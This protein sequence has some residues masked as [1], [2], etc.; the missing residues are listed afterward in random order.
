MNRRRDLAVLAAR[1][2]LPTPLRGTSG[3]QR[4]NAILELT[5]PK[6]FVQELATQELYLLMHDIG[7]TDAYVLIEHA[8]ESQLEELIALDVW[9]RDDVQLERWL[10]W[11]DL[12]NACSHDVALRYIK[13]TDA[14]LLQLLLSGDIRVHG[15]DLDIDTVPDHLQLISS[16]DAMFK[17]TVPR[18]HPLE[19]RLP[20]L[21]KLLWAQS[22][23][24]MRTI[25]TATQF[26]LRAQLQESLYRF[27]NG[28]LE[29]MGLCSTEHAAEIYELVNPKSLRNQI[30]QSLDEL[31]TIRPFAA[32]TTGFDLVLAGT[33]A[34]D[35]LAEALG[36]AD[37][38][39]RALFGEA[40]APRSEAD[41]N[42][43][44]ESPMGEGVAALDR[45]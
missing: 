32:A 3:M 35:F 30:R 19:E 28:R 29:D 33:E 41:P 39:T 42:G 45:Q 6:T 40:F 18:E 5:D 16:P 4:L 23:D 34:P 10:G 17:L 31:A 15:K 43:S 44:S 20:E 37:D 13:S 25:C 21:L 24:R 1:H 12:A 26:E 7:R 22:P 2:A 9:H 14:Q 38:S 11:L 8:S 27:R 36:Q